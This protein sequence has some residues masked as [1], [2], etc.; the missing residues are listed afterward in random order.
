MI[1]IGFVLVLLSNLAFGQ[2]WRVTDNGFTAMI[3]LSDKPEEMYHAW[4]HGLA[5]KVKISALPI[6]ID[7]TPFEAIIIFSGCASDKNGN[8]NVVANWIV[9]NSSGEVLGEIDGA[10]LW[11]NRTAPTQ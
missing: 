11:V 8:C 9:E 1:Q 7:G 10:P 4:N 6:V 5:N 2:E 3:F